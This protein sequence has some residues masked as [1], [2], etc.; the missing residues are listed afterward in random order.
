L[1]FCVTKLGRFG[2]STG[3]VGLWKEKKQHALAAEIRKRQ[4]AALVCFQEKVRGFITDLQHE[5]TSG[6]EQFAQD[7]VDG[8]R[9]SLTARGAHD[10]ADEKL[11]D[12]FVAAL[13]LGDVLGIF[14][15]NL[16]SGLFD[17]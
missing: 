11:E 3:C 15:N 14:L 9:I 7:V 13:K 1:L 5:I 12:A 17:F 2:R 4:F 8:L 6:N 16:A 10:L